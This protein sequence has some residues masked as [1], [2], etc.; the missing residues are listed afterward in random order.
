M[1]FTRNAAFAATALTS[2]LLLAACGGSSDGGDTT[3]PTDAPVSDCATGSIKT[4]GSSAQANAMSVWI[5]DYQIACPDATIDYQ[6]VGSGAGVEQ[7]I[8]GQTSF[9]G[10]D[11]AVTDEDLVAANARCEVGA[12]INIPMVGG[13]IAIAYNVE[14][15]DSLTLT[16]T[17]LAGIF[18]N[19]ITKWNDPAI[20]ALNSGANLPDATI[21][22]FHRSDSSGTT[23]NFSAFLAATAPDVWTFDGGK[24]WI[25]PGGQGAKGSDQVAASVEQTPNSMGYVELSFILEAE[26]AKGALIDN[27]AGPVAPTSQNASNAITLATQVGTGDDLALQLD[28]AVSSADAYPIVLVTYETACQAGLPADQNP[29]LVSS[30]LAFAASDAGQG[31][32]SAEGY[33]PISGDLLTKVR[34]SVASLATS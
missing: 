9:A 16:P 30:F 3:A 29:A 4:A 14:G 2:A 10:T 18:A 23:D 17:V 22:R 12:A 28:Y 13:A 5:T 20:A 11:S 24:D 15:L 25:A 33:V 7:F 27:G 19:N 26:N 34:A 6:P 1:R 31:L 32:L 8:A 21:A